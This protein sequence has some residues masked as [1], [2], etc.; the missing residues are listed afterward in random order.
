MRLRQREEWEQIRS[1]G[2]ARFVFVSGVVG[3]GLPVGLA[4]SLAIEIVTGEPIPESL[5]SW[6]FAGRT[7]LAVAVFSISGCLTAHAAWRVHERRFS[8]EDPAPKAL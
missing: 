4:I 6:R 5:A 2:R 3:R 7:L 8:D 1:R